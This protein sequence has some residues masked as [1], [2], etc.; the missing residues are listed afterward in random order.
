[1]DEREYDIAVIGSG[2]MGG[3]I[4]AHI[5]NAGFPVLLL[6]I[7]PDAARAEGGDRSAV[8]RAALDRLAKAEPAAF[9]HRRNA[10]RVTPGNIEDDLG[11]LADFRGGHSAGRP[12]RH[13]SGRAADHR[14]G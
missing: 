9:M 6:D 13:R 4:A 3:G 1:M 8:A 11:K 12:G 7:V 14:A 2:V 10:R 5:A